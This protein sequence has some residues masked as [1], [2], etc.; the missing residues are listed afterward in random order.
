LKQSGYGRE[1][2]RDSIDS[3]T[4]ARSVYTRID[5]AF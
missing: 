1:C 3:Y 5:P 2:G 4:E